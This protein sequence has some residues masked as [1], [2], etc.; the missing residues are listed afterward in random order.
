VDA[1]PRSLLGDVHM[2]TGQTLRVPA[3]ARTVRSSIA[4]HRQPTGRL[5][6]GGPASTE[7]RE[8]CAR[9][10]PRR[11]HE[12]KNYCPRQLRAHAQ[13]PGNDLNRAHHSCLGRLRLFWD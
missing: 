5:R 2:D 9:V 1:I 8:N 12:P 13:C 10:V 4:D 6:P 3:L 7:K 11:T